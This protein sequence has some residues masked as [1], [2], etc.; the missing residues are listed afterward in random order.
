M[1]TKSTEMN[2]TTQTGAQYIMGKKTKLTIDN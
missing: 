1:K 2:L